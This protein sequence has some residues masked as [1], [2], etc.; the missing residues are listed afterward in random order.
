VSDCCL[1]KNVCATWSWLV[2]NVMCMEGVKLV[3]LDS[4]GAKCCDL[5]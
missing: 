4:D 2:I 5:L 3:E 1:V